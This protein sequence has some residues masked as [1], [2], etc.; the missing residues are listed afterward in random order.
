MCLTVGTEKFEINKKC[1]QGGLFF[2]GGQVILEELRLW[3]L[4][5]GKYLSIETASHDGYVLFYD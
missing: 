4:M 5:L 3:K 2:L 1:P